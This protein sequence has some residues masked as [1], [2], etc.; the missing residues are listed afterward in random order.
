MGGY[1]G[2]DH[3]RVRAQALAVGFA[4]LV[5]DRFAAPAAGDSCFATS[6]ASSA[7]RCICIEQGL[8]TK[9]GPY[10]PSDSELREAKWLQRSSQSELSWRVDWLRPLGCNLFLLI[11]TP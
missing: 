6:P 3:H 9:T 4:P 5:A 7:L 10:P 2:C 11:N 8:L 1:A